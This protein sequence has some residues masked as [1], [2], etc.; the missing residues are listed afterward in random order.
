M[1]HLFVITTLFACT[2]LFVQCSKA[3]E[4]EKAIAPVDANYE[5][6]LKN[7]LWAYYNFNNS[8][9]NDLSGKGR[10]MVGANGAKFSFDIWGNENN[11][12]DLNGVSSY[13]VIDSGKL[14]PDGNFTVSFLMMP[15]T[16]YGRP[17]QKAN[18]NDAKGASF[19]FGYDDDG[20]NGNLVFNVTK[21]ANICE[22]LTDLSNSTPLNITKRTYPYAW[23]YVVIQY[24]DGVQKVYYNRTLVGSQTNATN[25][26]KNCANAPFYLGIW[27]LGDVHAFNGKI[28]E[29]R[30]HTRAISEDEIKYLY[31]KLP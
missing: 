6:S 5:D 27:W 11:A 28:D 24:I 17:F 23:Y 21:D 4:E 26:F 19:G 13:A 14:F 15:R 2:L 12:L 18:P 3:R 25:S 8:N 31:N 1:R 9:Y 7:G 30:I 20:F 16:T 29:L 10:H 22:R